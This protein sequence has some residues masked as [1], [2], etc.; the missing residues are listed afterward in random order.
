MNQNCAD[1]S[2]ENRLRKTAGTIM[3][4]LK[5]PTELSNNDFDHFDLITIQSILL[6]RG[7]PLELNSPFSRG[8]SLTLLSY[9]PTVILSS[10]ASV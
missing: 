1:I 5:V 8:V 9:L 6:F 7:V 10:A 2:V 4:H 3:V